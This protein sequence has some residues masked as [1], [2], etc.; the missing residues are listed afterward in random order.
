MLTTPDGERLIPVAGCWVAPRNDSK[1][2]GV[3][4]R[5]VQNDERTSL[6]VYWLDTRSKEVVPLASVHCGFVADLDVLDV[7]NSRI[8]ESLGIGRV[9]ALRTIA[10]RE[11][12]LVDFRD[13]GRQAWMPYECL[14]QVKGPEFRFRTGDVGGPQ[15]AERFRL[16]TLA[17]A[18]ATWNEN[19]GALSRFDIDPLPHQIHLVH[20]I[21][22]SGNLNWLIADDV[23]L[24]KTIETG[25][26]IAALKQRKLASRVLI[27]VPA[28]LTRQWQED[29]KYKFGM[30]DFAIYGR[31]FEINDIGH[32]KLYDLVIGSLDRFKD[33]AHLAKLLQAPP[34]DLIVFDE[35]H[36]LSRRQYGLKFDYSERFRLSQ[37]LRTRSDNFVFLTATPHQ[38]MQDKF[39]ALL[40]L[41][42]PQWKDAFEQLEEDP[43]VLRRMVF[44]NRK[45]DVTDAQGNFIFR[46]QTSR[47]ISVEISAE[48]R[49]FDVDLSAYFTR[50][51]AAAGRTHGLQG[52]AIGFV[53]SVYRKLAASSVAAIRGALERRIVKL[54]SRADAGE[55]SPDT[56]P[57]DERY[58]GEWEEQ[59]SGSAREF[60]A[61]E[62]ETLKA[63]HARA[64]AL[65]GGDRKLAAFLDAIVAPVIADEEERLLIFSEYRGT[66]EYLR[67]ALAARYGDSTVAL[68]HGSMTVDERRAAIREFEEGGRFLISTE[69]GGEGINLQRRCHLLVNFDLP[70]NPMR[71]AQRIGRLY[72]YGQQ[73]H[74]VAFNVQGAQTADEHI[75]GVMYQRLDKVAKDMATVGEEY[76]ENLHAEILGQLADLLDVE[77]I[78]EEA[79]SAGIDRTK[80]RV[81][82]AL[83]RA[84]ESAGLQRELFRNAASYDPSSLRE[85][86]EL[87][88]EHL[89]AFV[90][91]MI[92]L[93]GGEADSIR[94]RGPVVR[95]RMTES[96]HQ[97]V[98]G[99]GRNIDGTFDRIWAQADPRL[100]MLDLAH[101]L[102][103]WLLDHAREYNFQGL[104]A[105]I[106]L[107]GYSAIVPFMLRWQN[108]HGQRV[109]QEFAVE[110][111][112]CNG[113]VRANPE[114]FGQWLLQPAETVGPGPRRDDLKAIAIGV[115]AAADQE[116]ARRSNADLHP[117]CAQWIAAAVCFDDE[118]GLEPSTSV[119]RAP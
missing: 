91:G 59:A 101:P 56:G 79:R 111:M 47:V 31:D 27:V 25:L 66:Q 12:V 30:E 34:W 9:V 103:A 7:P 72:R 60:F 57:E 63:L 61:G 22:A 6:T 10:D 16:R 33:E 97:A 23:G 85:S 26:L 37:A 78:L 117:M 55:W 77:Q 49:A 48:A 115:S 44:R 5:A 113:D 29:L 119:D 39:V 45:A 107:R 36:R 17:H 41:L 3:V 8:R 43:S 116:L 74:V 106:S 18:L 14:K 75:V 32:W 88:P 110:A 38:G 65:M 104:T 118:P 98:A 52:R 50:G 13:A 42:R 62:I 71:L 11:Q 112:N 2:H 58:E 81:D 35:A 92:R 108:D 96:M 54:Q 67:A 95:I 20:H 15:A 1:R 21:L 90:L 53:M 94:G 28:G 99:I 24:G 114:R 109:R 93:L 86:I 80:V 51:Y 87:G 46:G 84:Q 40:E 83:R 102:V 68:I 64:T 4:E 73:K 82:E 70:W 19:T 100:A 69:A 105:P 89:E 76:S